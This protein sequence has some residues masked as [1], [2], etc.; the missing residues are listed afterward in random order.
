MQ[1]LSASEA[2]LNLFCI[3]DKT[4]ETHQSTVI[5]C[6]HNAAKLLPIEDWRTILGVLT[7]TALASTATD[8]N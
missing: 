8:L 4:A 3:V 7:A 6:R 2:R 5:L 1:T